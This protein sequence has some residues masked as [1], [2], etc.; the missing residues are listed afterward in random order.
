MCSAP[1]LE[2]APV[3]TLGAPPAAAR[4]A[5]AGG[6]GPDLLALHHPAAALH[7]HVIASAGIGVIVI[8]FRVILGREEERGEGWHQRVSGMK[9]V[10]PKAFIVKN[11]NSSSRNDANVNYQLL[12]A[13]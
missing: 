5:L 11:M 6:A 3:T 8:F 4:H 1:A 7:Q 12:L 9:C 2:A 10:R 13:K